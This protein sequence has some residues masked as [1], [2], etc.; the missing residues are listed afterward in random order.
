MNAEIISI[1]D[2]LTSGQRLDTNSQWLS[3]Q[4]GDIGVRVLYHSTVADDMRAIIAVFEQAVARADLVVITGG[5]GPTADDL[6][7]D[8]IAQVAGV[9][10]ELHEPSLAYI[11][12]L[13]ASYGRK[14]PERNEVQAYIPRGGAPITNGHGTAPGVAIR[15]T[16]GD[17]TAR[18]YALPGVPAEMHQM[19]A[20]EVRDDIAA[21]MPE[22]RAIVYRAIKCFGQGESAVEA[23]LPDLVRRGREPSVGITVSKAT[24]TLRITAHADDE[25]ACR[26]LIQPTEQTIREC[27][28]DLVF[29]TED[30]ELQDAVVALLHKRRQTLAVAEWGTRGLVTHWL[31]TAD[32]EDEHSRASA[33]SVLR[34]AIVADNADAFVRGIGADA[35]EYNPSRAEGID[36]LATVCRDT[37][38]ADLALVIGPVVSAESDQEPIR[39]HCAVAHAGGVDTRSPH[40]AGP[41]DMRLDRCAKH[42]LDLLRHCLM[43]KS[44]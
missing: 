43:G 23:M 25:T 24:I 28:G 14:M 37:R 41:P 17:H 22:R 33:A 15:I 12:N 9:E 21:A 5:L 35:N 7:R 18:L 8:A 29:G 40:F 10:L 11:R 16:R 32:Q 44:G 31:Q 34:H 19:F 38:N 4:L 39:I 13:F 26:A 2:E 42:A 27:L 30:E 36:A 1:G 20:D 3:Q 6:T